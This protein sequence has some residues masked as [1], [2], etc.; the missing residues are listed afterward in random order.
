M[1]V[2]LV[3]AGGGVAIGGDS[4]S[5]TERE[6]STGAEFTTGYDW[7]ASSGRRE[8]E[9]ASYQVAA[10]AP[11]GCAL[12]VQQAVGYCG[13]AL[14]RTELFRYVHSDPAGNTKEVTYSRGEEEGG[15]AAVLSERELLLSGPAGGRWR[16][17]AAAASDRKGGFDCLEDREEG[18]DGKE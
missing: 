9:S 1:R 2:P 5:T 6:N 14:V 15:R 16:G 12:T 11:A 4:R 10:T 17:R 18:E 13:G 8:A 3:T 7:G